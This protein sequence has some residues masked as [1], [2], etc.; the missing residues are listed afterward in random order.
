MSRYVT[1]YTNISHYAVVLR[2]ITSTS[3]STVQITPPHAD[4]SADSRTWARVVASSQA[5]VTGGLH[6]PARHRMRAQRPPH[7][8]VTW[9]VA[10]D[11]TLA[12]A[13]VAQVTASLQT[14][15]RRPGRKRRTEGSREVPVLVLA[16]RRDA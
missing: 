14:R 4:S 1:V 10:A 13:R 5:A 6:T 7:P 8:A 9:V 2:Y 16:A 12:R 3:D 11:T 15:D